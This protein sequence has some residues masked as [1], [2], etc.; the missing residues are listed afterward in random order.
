MPQPP[1][2]ARVEQELARA[3][4]PLHKRSLGLALGFTS[5]ACVFLLTAFHI[6]VHPVERPPIV[7]LA[8]YFYGY[9]VTWAGAFAGL[10]WGFVAGFAAGWFFAFM[11]NLTT[12]AWVF[13][14]RTKASLQQTSDFLDHI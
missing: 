5:G 8:Q 10:W 12:A 1:A 7:L 6:V 4:A 9:D 2:P 14:I 13:F 3:F 11:R